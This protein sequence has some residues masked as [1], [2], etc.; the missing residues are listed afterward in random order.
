[1][2]SLTDAI[3]K[4][5]GSANAM[6]AKMG[7]AALPELALLMQE[8][9]F[10]LRYRTIGVLA[11]LDIS[12]SF[13]LVSKGLEDSNVNVVDATISI[14]EKQQDKLSNSLLVSLLN[15]LAEDTAQ[16]RIILLLG[17]R[18]SVA[19]SAPLEKY[20]SEEY[21]EYVALNAMA[22]LAKIGVE[23]R[24][25]QFLTYLNTI[26]NDIDALSD[27]FELVE[28]IDQI[29]LVPAL[30]LLL[31]NKNTCFVSEVFEPPII[32]VCDQVVL[33]IGALLP[34]LS[35]SFDHSVAAN[36]T[37]EQLAE[38]NYSASNYQY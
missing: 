22:A 1:M 31:S 5:T 16:A 30:K 29:W 26:Q 20:C 17:A 27:V 13:E 38:V 18:L 7:A 4:N 34:S 14:I 23:L 37:D 6:V 9:D 21:D 10:V 12:Q 25:K 28:Y 3:T 32:R 36:F 8:Q 35:L 24:R 19:E 11:E 2:S 33:F 15:K